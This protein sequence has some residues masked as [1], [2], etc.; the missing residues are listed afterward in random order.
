MN[1]SIGNIKIRDHVTWWLSE[2][3]SMLPSVN[4]PSINSGSHELS[5]ELTDKEFTF[6]WPNKDVT[7][8]KK[9]KFTSSEA[10]SS[11]RNIINQDGKLATN[12]CDLRIAEKLILQKE[13][14]L[15]LA[16]EENLENV[17]SYEIDRYTPFK[18]DDVYFNV[19][20]KERDKKE[21]KIIVILSVIRR[22]ILDEVLEF[23]KACDISVGEIYRVGNGEEEK[24]NFIG[25]LGD[26]NPSSKSSSA[27]KLLWLLV[28][29]LM[30]GA[31][32]MPIAKNYLIGQKLN[33]ELTIMQGEMT[34]ARE[35]LAQFKNA[36]NN[37]SMVEKLN[38][39]NTKVIKLLNDVSK[40][41]PDDTSLSRFALEEGVVRIQGISDSA[42]KLIPLLDASENFDE[43][44][45]V[46]P[47]T[48]S[49][50]SGKEKFTIEIKLSGNANAK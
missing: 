1:A 12:S 40:I 46:A 4:V 45:F 25:F 36:K 44:R 9:N 11:Y 14:T 41:I 26:V 30:A 38:L 15:P 31:L 23:S 37:V 3:A 13:I 34:E 20:V 29:L 7:E 32:I 39:N 17:I 22:R 6:S 24:I 27:N 50:D 19:N 42:S 2:L 10:V 8:S 43:V 18:K 21:K 5:L 35:L 16:T 47:V 28:A 33:N 49:G 48:Q